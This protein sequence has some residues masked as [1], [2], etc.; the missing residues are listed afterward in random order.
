MHDPEIRPGI[1][2]L[3]RLA[4]GG[5]SRARAEMDDEIRLHLKLRADQLVAEGMS[6]EEARREAER[7]FGPPDEARARLADS[8]ARR[9]TRLRRGEWLQGVRQGAVVALRGMR[10]APAF[11]A[12]TVACIALGVGA[13]A[14]AYSMFDELLLRPL[15]VPAPE[16]LVRLEAPGPKGGSDQCNQAGSCDEVF[17]LPM[18]RDLQRS[19]ATGL[20]SLAAHRLFVAGVAAEGTAAAQGDGVFV[21]GNYFSTL[22]LRP[23]LGRLLGPGDD[24]TPG[25]HPVAVV[26][27]GY[28]TTQLGADPSAIGRRIMLNGRALTIVGVA[29]RGF[30]G[31][32]LGV[33][34]WVYVPILMAAEVDPFFGSPEQFR[35]RSFYW[36]YAF[37]RL[38][39]ETTVD[40]AGAAL[41]GAYRSILAAVEAPLHPDLSAATM[42]RFKAKEIVVHDGSRGQ[43]ALRRTT[44]A[45]LLLLLG[46]TA[47]VVLIA[48][49]N[50]A[51]LLLVRGAGRA[52]EIAVRMSLGASR[53]QL[54]AQLLTESLVLAA[55]GGVASLAVAWATLRVIGSFIPQAT[56]G[57]GA[58]L[59]LELSPPVLGFA[60]LV[61]LGTGLLFGLFPALHGTR[62]DLIAAI[63]SGAG[64]LAGG[65]RAAARF[66]AVLVTAQIALSMALLGCAGLFVRSLHNVS[67]VD[68][69][70]D[71][72][73]VVQFGLLPQLNGYDAARAH[74]LFVRVEEELAAVPGIVAVS[75][76]GVPLLTGANMG[77]NV[78]VEG[79][80]A[81]PDADVN[82]RRN[83]VGPD[84]FR[85]MGIPL[86]AGREF[87]AGDRIGTPKVAVVNEAF[88]RKFGLGEAAIGRRVGMGRSADEPMDIEIV[89]LVRDASY[90]SVKTDAPAQLFLAYRQDS[91]VTAAAFYART[92]IPPAEALRAIPP[93]IARLDRNLPVPLL[94]P[95]SQQVREGLF[96]DRMVGTLSAGFAALATLLAAVGLYG[97]LAYTV[98]QR[99]RELGVRMALGASTWR[100][101]GMVLRQVAR[102]AV[103]GGLIGLAAAIALG[104]TAQSLL[105]GLDGRDPMVLGSAT[106]LLLL[107]ALAAAWL[108]ARRASRLSPATAL[109]HE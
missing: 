95:L 24:E 41:T 101:R 98:A 72:E 79:H 107:V 106:V 8:A 89:G 30:E 48:C 75:A 18:I 84:F 51:N 1:R 42:A 34:P 94:K 59:S 76:S 86:L 69:G 71:T 97:V 32:T 78:R 65:N 3:V 63:R 4:L 50:V 39:P 26:S 37:G 7:R 27:H 92:S 102:M 9:E 56:I 100:V 47:L 58:T 61:S 6:P 55:I 53:R 88:A 36:A 13:N 38:R 70:M 33:R 90:A 22:G 77:G 74:A 105:F 52:A 20:A 25:G 64:Q 5:A 19:P 93:V 46:I 85:T 40:Q 35:N 31:T 14:A 15:P 83:M 17:S 66:R 12:V 54:V 62:S 23:A 11:V 96:L 104:R 16:R 109:R 29:P 28:W 67:R 81:G 103:V 21:T 108:P 82:V 45:P 73:Q 99:T 10:R 80:D 57:F 49:A 91:T 68:L 60:A 44:E 43:S 87:T 2:R